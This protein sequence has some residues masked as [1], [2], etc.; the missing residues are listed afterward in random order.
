MDPKKGVNLL[1][2]IQVISDDVYIGVTL[3]KP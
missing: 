2:Q 3:V 1:Y